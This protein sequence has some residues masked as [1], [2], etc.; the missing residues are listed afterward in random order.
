MRLSWLSGVPFALIL[1]AGCLAAGPRGAHGRA[2]LTPLLPDL[3][4]LP[5]RDIQIG[6]KNKALLLSSVVGDVGLGPVELQG[7]SADS[8]D[9]T[10]KDAFQ[11]VY[12]ADG[13]TTTV[14]VGQFIWHEAHHHW[15]FLPELAHY[16]LRRP[17]KQG[18]PTGPIA[19]TASKATFCFLDLE[20]FNPRLPGSP[21]TAQYQDCGTHIQGIS[22]GWADVYEFFLPGQSI[23]IRHVPDG[24]Y[25]LVVTVDP[26]HALQQI[27]NENDFTGVRIHL[28]TNRRTHKRR[29]VVIR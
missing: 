25:W 21:G 26:Q 27:T 15:H 17:D 5:P 10:P 1:A 6:Q 22:V 20:N 14:K 12:N 7:P 11:N 19:G 13:P 23:D 28:T 29:V 8:P 4:P 18:G 3:V 9:H 24:V 16:E 2:A